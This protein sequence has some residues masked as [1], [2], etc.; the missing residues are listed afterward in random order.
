MALFITSRDISFFRNIN[1]ELLNNVIQTEVDYY[2]FNLNETSVNFYGEDNGVRTYFQ[3]VRLSCL[4]RHEPLENPVSEF[5]VD[6]DQ[7]VSFAFLR[8][9]ILDQLNLVPEIGDIINWN[10][11]YFEV[12][13][14]NINQLISGKNDMVPKSVGQDFGSDWSYVTRTHYTRIDKLQLENIKFGR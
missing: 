10:N 8:D 4:I 3:P 5:G 9:G 6:V 11:K 2:K 14:V 1:K 13:A 12:D 7:I